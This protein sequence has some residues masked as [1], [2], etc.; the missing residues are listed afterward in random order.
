MQLV[1]VL[2]TIMIVRHLRKKWGLSFKYM[3]NDRSDSKQGAVC[4]PGEC[5]VSLFLAVRMDRIG[6]SGEGGAC[7]GESVP[8]CAWVPLQA[9]QAWLLC[10][11]CVIR[12]H[13]GRGCVYAQ[14]SVPVGTQNDS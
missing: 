10:L 4:R 11:A 12:W 8:P 7:P 6:T 9:L 3:H 5:A 1:S 2:E 14:C 13:R